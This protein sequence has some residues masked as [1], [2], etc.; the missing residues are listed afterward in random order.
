MRGDI[1]AT[2]RFRAKLEEL[3][4]LGDP[5][6]PPIRR[7]RVPILRITHCDMF[8]F[9]RH[10]T[11]GSYANSALFLGMLTGV[12][13]S[14]GARPGGYIDPDSPP[15]GA[16]LDGSGYLVKVEIVIPDTATWRR[17]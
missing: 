5:T 12:L 2:V 16:V 9:R 17:H 14:M 15:D 11:L 13:T 3:E 6:A 1:K 4:T 7:V 10:P 8:A